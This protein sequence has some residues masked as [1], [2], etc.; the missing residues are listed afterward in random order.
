MTDFFK[1]QSKVMSLQSIII[2]D[3]IKIS[4]LTSELRPL[5]IV[6]IMDGFSLQSWK[7]HNPLDQIRSTAGQKQSLQIKITGAGN[8]AKGSVRSQNVIGYSLI[9]SCSLIYCLLD[10]LLPRVNNGGR[11]Y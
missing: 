10:T 2:N 7:V 8:G 1:I 4:V 11:V 3:N 9:V 6:Y 5:H